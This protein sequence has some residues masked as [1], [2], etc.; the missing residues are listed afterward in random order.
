MSPICHEGGEWHLFDIKI[1]IQLLL[2]PCVMSP[3]RIGEALSLSAEL[4]QIQIKIARCYHFRHE[5]WREE[6]TRISP[7]YHPSGGR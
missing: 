2:V 5:I 7:Q 1:K 3:L 4:C 6:V